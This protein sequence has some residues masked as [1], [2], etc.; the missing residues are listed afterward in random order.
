MVT[1]SIGTSNP[2]NMVRATFD[3]L[4]QLREPAFGRGKRR[5]K[6]VSDIL[7]ARRREQMAALSKPDKAG[8]LW[9]GRWQI[10]T[11]T[12]DAD[13]QPASRRTEP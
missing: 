2:Y 13:P 5:G 9:S 7:Q 4:K 3:A 10:K 8:S 12:V 11:V 6:K 1:K